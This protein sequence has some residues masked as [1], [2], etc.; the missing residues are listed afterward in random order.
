VNTEC[1]LLLLR[2]AFE[3]LAALRVEF[4]TDARNE[5]SQ[6]A[7]ARIGVV[8]EGTRR[9]HLLLPDGR[10][11]DSVYSSVI[12]EEWPDVRRLLEALRRPDPQPGRNRGGFPGVAAR[13][14]Q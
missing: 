10:V 1:K 4:K 2:H 3:D 12:A 8:R 6:R 11:R 9:R 7:L 13:P 14:R 5:R